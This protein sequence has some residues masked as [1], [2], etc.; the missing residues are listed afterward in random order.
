VRSTDKTWNPT[1]GCDRVRPGCDNCYAA[2]LA[3]RLKA[4]GQAKYQ[5]DGNPATSGPG[6]GVAVHHD[7]LDLP[8][9][10]RKPRRVFVDSMSDLSGGVRERRC[11]T[12]AGQSR[13]RPERA[14]ATRVA[15]GRRSAA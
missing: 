6:F 8:L 7:V 12:A 5:N 3:G 1:T 14:C 4:M 15:D 10:W 13:R 9:R 2:T 11:P